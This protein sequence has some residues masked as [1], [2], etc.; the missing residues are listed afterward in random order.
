[1]VHA[2]AGSPRHPDLSADGTRVVFRSGRSGDSEIYVMNADGKDVRR[3][4]DSSG[5]DTMPAISPDGRWTVYSTSRTGRGMK[6]WM[7]SLEDPGD[8]GHE[9]EPG[10]SHLFGADM[11]PRFS[12]DGRWVVFTSD[13][14]GMRDEWYLSALGPQPYG[15]LFALRA[16]GTGPAVQLTNDKWEDGLRFW[17][18]VN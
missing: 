11:H 8:P 12:P 6:L 2:V 5:T 14:A 17:T 1:V 13:R 18:A 7:Q 9:L 15:D 16:D 4:S 3:I 10:R